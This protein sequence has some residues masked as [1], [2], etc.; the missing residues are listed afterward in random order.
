MTLALCVYSML[1][2][3][4][5]I[6]VKPRNM[7]LFSCHFANEC[8]QITQGFRFVRYHYFMT[9]EQ[10]VECL[11]HFEKLKAVKLA[12]RA[13]KSNKKTNAA[14]VQGGAATA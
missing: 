11:A 10:R 1:F 8:A 9:D 7:L 13:A 2:M 4:F 3:R 14:S 5:A 12:E 6:K